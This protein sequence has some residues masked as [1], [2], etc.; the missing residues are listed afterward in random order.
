MK[1]KEALLYEKINDN[2]VKCLICN[3]FCII[4][5]NKTGICGAKI[6]KKGKLYQLL[7][8]KVSAIHISPQEIKP[9]FHFYPGTFA[10]SLGSQGCNFKCKGCQNWL[11]SQI[12]ISKTN[13]YEK[14]TPNKIVKIAL[15]NKL[16]GLSWTYNEPTI[17]FEFILDTSELA[18]KYNLTVSLV[19][20]G[21][22]TKTALIKLAPFID[23][24]RVDIKGFSPKTYKKLTSFD[25]F[26]QIIENVE[27]MRNKFNKHIEIVTNII[28]SFN[29]NME[30]I[31]N[32]AK[33]IKN[34]LGKKIPWHIT[35]FFPHYELRNLYPTNPKFL[36]EVRNM[37]IGEGLEFVYIGNLIGTDAENTY[38]PKCKKLNIE[39]IN[40]KVLKNLTINGRCRYCGYDLAIVC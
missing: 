9:L 36:F 40:A 4:K 3:N 8:G 38:C 37:A 29:D 17:W 30:E 35:R 1:L 33:W 14:L 26:K 10:L 13:D 5:E 11:L 6:Y 7:Y 16:N 19:T 23:A 28:P 25:C 22:I 12:P 31:K 32:I 20:N 34:S 18:K 2:K 39:R 21:N 24:Y 15:E 27:M